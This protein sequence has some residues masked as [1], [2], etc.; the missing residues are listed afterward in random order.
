M[1]TLPAGIAAHI[2]DDPYIACHLIELGGA[3]THYWT[4]YTSDLVWN[5]HTW[6]HNM[7][8]SIGQIVTD[9]EGIQDVT[10]VFDEQRQQLQ[11]YDQTEGLGDRTIRVHEAWIDPT[12]KLTVLAAGVMVDIA[13]GATAGVDFDEAD[14]NSTGTLI[15]GSSDGLESGTGPRNEYGLSCTN[16]FGDARCKATV[17]NTTV[18]LAL[19][20]TG[21]RTVTPASMAGILNGITLIVSNADG[22]N[23]EAVVVTA[24]TGTT[25]TAVFAT[26][27]AAAW[28]VQAICQRTYA[29]CQLFANTPN[30]RGC[31]FAL[32]P[33]QTLQWGAGSV[34]LNSRPFP[35]AG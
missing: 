10:I 3:V 1:L 22:T 20:A 31:R 6:L 32:T 25:F 26:T 4:D 2:N 13:S 17:A 34:V 33:P 30:F 7:P 29:A 21:S 12:D 16:G 24:V 18:A 27:K 5:G 19:S 35:E 9:A 15:L 28:L 11:G 8:F 23:S 14:S